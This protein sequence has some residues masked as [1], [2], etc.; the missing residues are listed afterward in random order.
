MMARAGFE[1]RGN[2]GESD[3]AGQLLP[4]LHSFGV[5]LRSGCGTAAETALDEVGEDFVFAGVVT[6][7]FPVTAM[8]KLF[9]LIAVTAATCARF[10]SFRHRSFLPD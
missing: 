7:F 4:L 5:G 8:F 2:G 10:L 6:L 1:E 3:G 9:V